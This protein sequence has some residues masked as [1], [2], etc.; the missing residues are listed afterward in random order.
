MLKVFGLFIVLIGQIVGQ[1][2]VPNHVINQQIVDQIRVVENNGWEA[3]DPESNP[4]RGHS[5]QE[6]IGL[7]GTILEPRKKKK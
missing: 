4:M 2:V 1:A 7:C 3:W 6:L 5:E